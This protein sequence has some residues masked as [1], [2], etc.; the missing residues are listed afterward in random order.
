MKS[1]LVEQLDEK[2]SS[3]AIRWKFI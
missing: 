1:H 2:S 3:Y